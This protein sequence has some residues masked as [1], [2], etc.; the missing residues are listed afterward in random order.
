MDRGAATIII[1]TL[2]IIILIVCVCVRASA[3][4]PLHVSLKVKLIPL[5]NF[6][7]RSS[8]S[9]RT[10]P[11]P[12][13][14]RCS[15]KCIELQRLCLYLLLLCSPLL[16]LPLHLSLLYFL[17]S[18]LV[19]IFCDVHWSLVISC[20]SAA[21]LVRLSF[22]QQ[23]QSICYLRKGGERVD[24]CPLPCSLSPLTW[25][26][27]SIRTLIIPFDGKRGS[28]AAAL[29]RSF[30]HSSPLQRY[31]LPEARIKLIRSKLT[32]H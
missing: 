10:A 20:S 14:Q 23:P 5:G 11:H 8:V 16:M 9:L 28:S 3:S 24:K 15:L 18:P 2:N 13:H 22:R 4:L 21:A 1:I 19:H 25:N 6:C 26:H 12:I 7:I 32:E 17:G 27:T 31:V 29:D 30:T